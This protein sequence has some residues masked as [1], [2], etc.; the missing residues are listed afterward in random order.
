[1]DKLTLEHLAPYLPYGLKAEM[2]DYKCDYVG[3]Q[4]DEIVGFHQWD[5]NC[6]YWSA[7]TVG[8]SK[9]NIERIKPILRPLSDLSIY[10]E[11]FEESWII[12]L[13]KEC[14]EVS[15]AG[16]IWL[17]SDL[18]FDLMYDRYEPPG[19]L[20][21]EYTSKSRDWLVKNQFDVFGLIEK[22]LA[23]D[24]NSIEGKETNS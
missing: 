14:I 9:P 12:R 7:L 17:D 8:G 19:Y 20:R 18:D 15:N 16:G 1:M 24:I 11:S 13:N 21:L 10:N 2:L 22:G 6:S 4:Y 3:K 23:I 5:K